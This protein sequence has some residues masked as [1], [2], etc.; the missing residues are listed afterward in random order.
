MRKF[1][2]S[3]VLGLALAGLASLAASAQPAQCGRVA[4]GSSGVATTLVIPGVA[5][6]GTHLCG[7]DVTA[8]AIGT[9][10]LI[11]GT[12]ATCGTNTVNI[13]AAHSISAQNVLSSSGA[14]PGRFSTPAANNTCVIVTGTG[15]IQWTIYYTQF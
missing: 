3:A 9:W 4:V 10:Q 6:Q 8:T 15:P 1:L 12:G 11:T 13:T 7:W 2:V 5:G 14:T